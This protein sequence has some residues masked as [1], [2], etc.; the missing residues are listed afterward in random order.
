MKGARH[1][2]ARVLYGEE[3]IGATPLG[4]AVYEAFARVPFGTALPEEVVFRGCLQAFLGKERSAV[5]AASVSSL[6]F[7]LWHIAPTVN[8]MHSNAFSRG[9]PFVFQVLWLAGTVVATTASGLALAW[10]RLASG[11]IVAPWMAHSTANGVGFMAA[12]LTL[13]RARAA[14]RKELS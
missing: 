8:R 3:R 1:G 10:L 5:T 11:S 6:L 4:V 13:R 14:S 7:G 9:R 12:W 2:R